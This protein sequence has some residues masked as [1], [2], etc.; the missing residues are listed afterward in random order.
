MPEP[1]VLLGGWGVYFL[2]NESF[3]EIHGSSY[4]GSRD[5]DI[6]FHIDPSMS[7]DELKRSPFSLAL[8]IIEEIGYMPMG[9][10][11]YYKIVHSSSGRWL[12]EKEACK[13]PSFDLFHLY[14]DPIVDNLHPA[15]GDVFKIKPIDDPILALA[16]N[17]NRFTTFIL[18]EHRI[19]VPDPCVMVAMKLA[20][21]PGRQKDDKRVKDA[22]DLYALLWHSPVGFR[23]LSAEVKDMF[24]DLART[25]ERILDDP[26]VPKAC[27]HLGI[28]DVTYREVLNFLL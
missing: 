15:H 23:P 19:L 1:L 7:V 24:P 10:S 18:D 12:D 2:V 20:S 25:A 22:C 28:E 16:F 11:R 5:V 6:G 17:K 27:H 14:L 4:L 21:F 8:D 3:K 13:Y 26:L 9:T